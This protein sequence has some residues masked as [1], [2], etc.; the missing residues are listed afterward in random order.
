M[1]T[2]ERPWLA[3]Y[4]SNVPADIDTNAY[5]S[6]AFAL[7]V[8][9]II[10]PAWALGLLMLTTRATIDPSPDNGRYANWNASLVPPICPAPAT[11]NVPLEYVAFPVSLTAPMSWLSHEVGSGCAVTSNSTGLLSFM[12]GAM[13]ITR[14][15]VVAPLGT[16]AMMEPALQLLIVI[17]TPFIRT[18][19]PFCEAPKFD[20]L[21]CT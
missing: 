19:L 7:S 16:V 1:N 15:P 4:P 8:S 2:N 20:P 11:V 6:V 21:I 5:A 3:S 9:R 13:E 17:A 12:L 14:S 10:T 18:K